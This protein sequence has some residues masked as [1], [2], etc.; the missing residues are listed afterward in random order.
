MAK[1]FV[2]DLHEA[3]TTLKY[4]IR[5]RDSTYTAAFDAVCP[6]AESRSSKQQSRYHE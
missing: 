3:S 1:N 5:D 6:T 4:L 2:M